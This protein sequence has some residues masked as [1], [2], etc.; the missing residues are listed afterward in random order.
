MTVNKAI[1]VGRLGADHE[2]SKTNTDST[3]VKLSL[4]TNEVYNDKSG[5]RQERTQWHKVIVWSDKLAQMIGKYYKKGD[6][7][8]VEGQIENRAYEQDGVKRYISEV[9]VPRYGGSVKL[10]L[11]NNKPKSSNNKQEHDEGPISQAKKEIDEANI[12][13]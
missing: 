1:L 11:T 7:V 10:I 9:V 2:I 8:A 6:T 13:F 3:F 5:E 12:P 4:A